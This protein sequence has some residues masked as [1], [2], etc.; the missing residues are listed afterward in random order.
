[1]D[2]KQL[3]PPYQHPKVSWCERRG[4]LQRVL[5]M[6]TKSRGHQREEGQGCRFP[7]NSQQPCVGFLY[8]TQFQ[9]EINFLKSMIPNLNSLEFWRHA[10]WSH[11]IAPAP[12]LQKDL[13]FYLLSI[14]H[15]PL[16]LSVYK[17]LSRRV[18]WENPWVCSPEWMY[19]VKKSWR[20]QG[21]YTQTEKWQNLPFW[22]IYRCR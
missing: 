6:K 21:L 18:G 4:A 15:S 16:C 13:N 11:K 10:S 8:S 3:C 2:I 7:S 14:S 12:R 9:L 20:F 19:T 5:W 22:S 17:T 1:M